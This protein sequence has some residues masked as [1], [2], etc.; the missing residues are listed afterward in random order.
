MKRVTVTILSLILVSG[1]VAWAAAQEP[2]KKGEPWVD[3]KIDE[4]AGDPN[5]PNVLLIGDSI[6]LGYTRPVRELLKGQANVFHSPGNAGS[7][8]SAGGIAKWIEGKKWAVVHFNYGIWDV[9]HRWKTD[10]TGKK[11]AGDDT[12]TTLEDYEKHLRLA[13]KILKASGT[14]VIF[15]TTTPIPPEKQAEMESVPERNEIAKKVMKENDVVVDDLY[16]YILPRQKELQ[17]PNNVHWGP[18][19]SEILAES[20]AA[21]IKAQLPKK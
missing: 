3:P 8:R 14:R 19:G 11:T 12:V 17:L 16:T 21:S 20:V 18:K 10:A 2:G 13:V 7:S 9:N 4:I 6:S 1:T 15:G 5:L